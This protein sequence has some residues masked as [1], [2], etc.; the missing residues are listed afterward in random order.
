[1]SYCPYGNVAEEAIYEVYQ[2]MGDSVEWKPHYVL[3]SNYAGGGPEYC[4]DEDDKY[5]SMHGIQELNQNIRETCVLEE[6]GVEEWFKF[7]AE[8]NE[9]CTYQNADTCWEAVADEMGYDTETIAACE[10]DKGMDISANDLEMSSVFGARGSPAVYI[11]G[12]EFTGA[13]S[14]AGYQ[15]A[16]CQ[17]FDDAPEVCDEITASSDTGDVPAGSCG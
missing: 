2:L 6:Y 9:R 17:A 5:C 13:R 8:M 7:A 15:Q 11:D 4:L 10:E 16:L 3:Y 14:P 1:M 12:V